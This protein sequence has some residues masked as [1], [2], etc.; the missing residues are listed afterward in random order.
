MLVVIAILHAVGA[1]S[2]HYM[3]VLL[4]GSPL[5][6]RNVAT[7][8]IKRKKHYLPSVVFKVKET[9]DLTPPQLIP[10][11]LSQSEAPSDPYIFK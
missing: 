10:H 3:C 9:L 4:F 11:T 8:R 7:L 1:I 6:H 2:V 5:T